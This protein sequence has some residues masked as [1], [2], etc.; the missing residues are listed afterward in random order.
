MKRHTEW[1]ATKDFKMNRI[2][3]LLAVLTAL[4][5]G[6]K[7]HPL[8]Q[9]EMPI[10][11]WYSITVP[12]LTEENHKMLK[13]CGFTVSFSDIKSMEDGWKALEMGE[14]TGI[15]VMYSC[16]EM[17]ER[18]EEVVA[19][20]KD[21]PALYG[22]FLRDEPVVADFPGL[23]AFSARVTAVDKEHPQYLNLFPNYV[24]PAALGCTYEEYVQAFVRQVP[25]PQ[26]SFDYYPVTIEG[27]RQTWWENLEVIARES[28][29]AG[30]PFWAF[31][32]STAHE[33]YPVPTLPSLRLQMYTNLAYGAQCLQYF[34][35]W[36][37]TGV[38]ENGPVNPPGE[39]SPVYD[40]VREM[41]AEV[42][43]RAGVFV[44]ATV[45]DVS[46][47]GIPWPEG[48]EPPFLS[49][50]GKY[51]PA[52][53]KPLETLP[54]GISVL[55]TGGY[56]LLVS[57]LRNGADRYLVLVNRSLTEAFDYRIGFR[58]A[59]CTVNRDRSIGR[60]KKGEHSLHL[61]EGDCAIFRL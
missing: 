8:P 19:A 29:K 51:L 49:H 13:D 24:N 48:T 45:E 54:E 14:K 25:L 7:P 55:D 6:C 38:K 58:K 36:N 53:V 34:T 16:P 11:A 18:P 40:I 12:Y 52:G 23:A 35:Y 37:S 1:N 50:S 46:H 28:R 31:A 22:Y 32:L 26:L 10:L 5:S 21:H 4:L 27:I 3:T 43:A 2:I 20:V 33:I 42:Q 61:A 17:Y 15:K 56:G 41:N 30:I 60:L 9:A 59:V 39:K 57:Q 44:G 47:I